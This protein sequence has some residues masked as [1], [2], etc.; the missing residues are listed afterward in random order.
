M[1]RL[2]RFRTI[3][4]LK[5][6][7]VMLI[8]FAAV[9]GLGGLLI[10]LTHAAPPAP[11]IYLNPSTVT[12]GPNGTF[13][14]Q[15]RENSGTTGVNALQ[16]NF[17]YPSGLVTCN[18]IDTS[19]SAFSVEAQSTCSGGQVTIARGVAGGSAALTGDQ[20]VA[21]VNFTADASSGTATMAFTTGTA[22]VSAASNQDILGSLS[23]TGGGTYTID[24][25]APTVSVTAP[26]NNATVNVGNVNITASATDSSTISNVKFYIDGTLVSTDTTSP[27]AYTWAAT[28]GAHTIQAK[29]TDA[30]N[31]VGSSSIVNVTVADQTP[32]SVSMT[33]PS[34][35]TSLGATT[36]TVS[37]TASDNVGVAGVQFKLDGANLGAEDTT[38]PYSISWNTATTSSGSHTLTA[39]A[40][41]AAGNTTTATAVTVT[42][43]NT[44]PTVSITAPTAGSTVKNTVSITAAATDNTGGTGVAK[45]EFYINGTLKTTAT[46]SPYT[47]SW[48]TTAAANGSYTLSAKAYDAASPANVATSASVGVTVNNPDAQPP[49]TPANFKSTGSTLNSISLSWNAS[50]DNVG[51]TGYQVKRNG[52]L[53]TTTPSLTFTDTGL[54]S[55]TAYSYTVA[56]IDAAGN[57]SATAGPLN[58]T[59][60]TPVPGDVDGD[61]HVT[62]IDL[63][64]LLTHYGQ[65]Y[66]AA[67]FNSDGTV[68]I[69]DLS[70]LLTHYGQ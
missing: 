24:A 68:N 65:T 35:G 49:T 16:A 17:S 11:T 8:L 30:Y 21:V 31:N 34:N 9:F 26:A 3:R 45:V 42:V 59:T 13:S 63:S 57:T 29:A 1:K 41:D 69:L 53:V 14:V 38:S 33:A 44:A 37:A 28:L 66:A 52:T 18:S 54:S 27:Y 40:R 19:S 12:V 48:D 64:I 62:I 20:L 4:T 39:V 5:L 25:T 15:V 58:V 67:D 46:S 36:T 22:L 60:L 61:G 10:I 55:S 7:P 6:N 2:K 50:T 32:P 47:Y 56:A 51:V 43:D 23:A 70:I